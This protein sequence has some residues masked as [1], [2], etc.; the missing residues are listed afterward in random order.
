MSV[1]GGRCRALQSSAVKTAL[2]SLLSPG[3]ALIA[4]AV[5]VVLDYMEWVEHHPPLMAIIAL[6]HFVFAWVVLA[7]VVLAW[8][9][10]TG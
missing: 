2:R 1:V 3:L 4:L 8:R 5:S 6:L 7:V 10:F 9:R